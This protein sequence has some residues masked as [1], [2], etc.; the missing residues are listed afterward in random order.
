MV[1]PYSVR[2]AA[3]APV[4]APLSWEEVAAGHLRPADFNLRTMPS[5]VQG[6]GDLFALVLRGK[7]RLPQ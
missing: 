6:V 5:R 7:Q 1:A 3:R 2:A 4:A